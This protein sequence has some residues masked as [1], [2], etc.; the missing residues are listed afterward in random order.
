MF[1]EEVEV[2]VETRIVD[3]CLPQETSLQLNRDA[4]KTVHLLFQ[5]T[6]GNLPCLHKDIEKTGLSQ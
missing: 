3:K 2:V 5:I 1:L 4:H 6:I